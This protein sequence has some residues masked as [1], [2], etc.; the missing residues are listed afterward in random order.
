[1]QKRDGSTVQLDVCKPWCA[2]V[3]DS[4]TS[5]I[6]VPK[7]T[8]NEIG[9]VVGQVPTNCQGLDA[10]P[11]LRFRLGG[12]NFELPPEAY[13]VRIHVPRAKGITQKLSANRTLLAQSSDQVLCILAMQE[14][15]GFGDE[16]A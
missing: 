2:A 6:T 14:E 15:K 9:K 12:S 3:V 8:L 16:D 13:V 1:M 5:L 4:G 7:G 11:T 10:L